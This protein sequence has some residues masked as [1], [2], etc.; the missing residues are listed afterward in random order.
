MK[1]RAAA[2][3]MLVAM[4]V[5]AEEPQREPREPL[6][7]PEWKMARLYVKRRG[8]T[9]FRG[10]ALY[11]TE[12][13]GPS[14][15][16]TCQKKQVFAFVSVKALSL[17]EIFEKWFRNPAEWN[18]RFQIDDQP[19]R[20]ETWIWTYGGRVFMSKPGESANDLFKAARNGE[21]LTFK[22]RKKEDPVTFEIPRDGFAQ[23]EV[24]VDKCGLD[25]TDFG[26]LTT[27]RAP[28]AAHSRT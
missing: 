4:P 15:G 11:M 3:A 13:S 1:L 9:Y 27:R 6:V 23:F 22:S 28:S 12:S 17:G 20:D 10:R 2:L 21:T 24:F 26:S 25:L 19:P 8:K 7:E 5:W 18:V 16:F 14:I